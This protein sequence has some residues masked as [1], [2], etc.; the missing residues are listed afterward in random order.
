MVSRAVKRGQGED[1]SLAYPCHD[2]IKSIQ[3]HSATISLFPLLFSLHQIAHSKQED[4]FGDG[5][6]AIG[7]KRNRIF[8]RALR[9][10]L[11]LDYD[12]LT[13]ET[14]NQVNPPWC[15]GPD[16]RDCS[17]LSSSIATNCS[18]VKCIDGR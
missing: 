6:R 1:P 13:F 14:A 4:P 5:P 17:K 8:Q 10:C 16:K 2:K 11:G 9:E 7:T 3:T 12:H 18:G 15:V